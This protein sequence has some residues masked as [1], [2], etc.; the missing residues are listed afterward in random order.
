MA[1]TSYDGLWGRQIKAEAER[2]QR[3]KEPTP[4]PWK[5][6]PKEGQF[7]VDANRSIVAE[8]P[9]QGANPADGAYI[10]TAVNEREALLLRIEGLE[11]ALKTLLGEHADNKRG[12]HNASAVYRL[13][14]KG[15]DIEVARTELRC[16][17]MEGLEVSTC[18]RCGNPCF[19]FLCA[20][21]LR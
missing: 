3:M 19:G 20:E 11:K 12:Q 21:C 10:V 8:I 18:K 14:V 4:R 17:D 7:I 1:N 9:C 6:L 13:D 15:W 16:E 5:W 2:K